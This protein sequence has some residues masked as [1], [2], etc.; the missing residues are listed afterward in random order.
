MK[1]NIA[2]AVAATFAASYLAGCSSVIEGTSQ[3]ILVNTNPPGAACQFL[4]EGNV[5]ASVPA[6]PGGVTIKKTKHD[7]TLK[8]NKQGYQEATYLNHSGAAGATFGNI[9]LGGGIGWAIDSASG[10]DNKYD[11][12]VNMTLVPA[13]AA[14]AATG[15]TAANIADSAATPTIASAASSN[16]TGC[17]HEQQVQARI[18]K[19][20]GYTAGP[21]CD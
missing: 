7:I 3:E 12:V 6:T 8:C 21:R 19:Q 13:G 9:V 14:A 20:N 4:R 1:S 2:V 18:A 15:P 17:T 11:G 16:G 5:I 10:A